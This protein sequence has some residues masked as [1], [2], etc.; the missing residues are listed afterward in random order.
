MPVMHHFATVHFQLHALHLNTRAWNSY[1]ASLSD[2]Q[3]LLSDLEPVRQ[4]GVE[5]VFAI[6]R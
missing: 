5:I 6:E 3:P 4:I 1:L 2:G